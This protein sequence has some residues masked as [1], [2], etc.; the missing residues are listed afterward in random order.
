V[1]TWDDVRR[2]ALGHEGVEQVVSR[3]SA[4]WRTSRRQ[5]VWERPLRKTDL[6]E[7]GAEAPSGPVLAALV[8]D[9][10]EKL[11][12]VADD[13]SVFFTTSHFDGHRIVLVRLDAIRSDRLAELIAAA[14][15]HA[16]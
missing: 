15:E 16:N 11:A 13:P 8:E 5:L 7:L 6:R 14:Y 12:L 9:E 3:G 4:A 2:L 1:A 10:G